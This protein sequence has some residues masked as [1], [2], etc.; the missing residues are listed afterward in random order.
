MIKPGDGVKTINN[1]V[2]LDARP[3]K[4]WSD[5]HIPGALSFSWENYTRVDERGVPYRILHL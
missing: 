1:L 2:I 5:G 3:K 4:V